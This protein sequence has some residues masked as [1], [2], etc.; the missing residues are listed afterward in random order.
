MPTEII[1]SR[2]QTS[3]Y[4]DGRSSIHSAAM[5]FRTEGL[6][7]FYRGFGIT[8][9]RE[10]RL[11]PALLPRPSLFPDDPQLPFT[12]IQF[13]LYEGLKS[14]LSRNYLDGRRPSPTEAALCGSVAGGTAAIA[15]TPL[16]VVKTR[17]M[18]ELRVE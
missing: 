2:T 8:I 16:D 10:V 4:G 9:A 1:K 11:P 6:R 5:T 17:V 18:L 12:S 13:P 14:S 15:T 7:G 3:A